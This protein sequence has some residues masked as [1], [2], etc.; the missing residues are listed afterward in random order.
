M[1]TTRR[2][3]ICLH[4]PQYEKMCDN[5]ICDTINNSTCSSTNNDSDVNELDSDS[6]ENKDSILNSESLHE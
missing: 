3:S 5:S 6:L 4:G 2:Q 1:K